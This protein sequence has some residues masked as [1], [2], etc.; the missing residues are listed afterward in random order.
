MASNQRLSQLSN[1]LDSNG[2]TEDAQNNTMAPTKDFNIAIVGGGIAGLTLAIALYQR[3]VPVTIYEQ[4]PAFGEIGAGVSFSPNAV[5]AMEVCHQG[6]HEAFEQVC[7]RNLWPSKKNVWFDYLDG[8]NPIIDSEGKQ[9]A[10]FTISNSLG[11]DGVHRA[12]FLEAMV[13]L[14]PKEI[15]KFGKRLSTITEASSGKLVMTFDDGSTAEA[16]AIIG[17]DGIKSRVRQMMVGGDHPSAKPTYTH[18]YYS[19]NLLILD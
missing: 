12:H 10:A 7:T 19:M 14:V 15:A 17:C 11:Q 4:A 5:Q 16:D 8:Y 9:E 3:Q 1:H 6:I 18:K 2:N 13:K